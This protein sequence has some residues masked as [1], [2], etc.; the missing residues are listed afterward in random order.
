MKN[1]L[2]SSL[3]VLISISAFSQTNKETESINEYLKSTVIYTHKRIISNASQNVLAH[4]I[5]ESELTFNTGDEGSY[6]TI[7]SQYYMKSGKKFISFPYESEML[8]SPEFIASITAKKFKLITNDDGV[9]FQSIL[10]LMD[11]NRGLGFFKED[12]SWYFIRSKFFDDI[13]AYVVTTDNKGQITKL[14][15]VD[16]LENKLPETLLKVGESVRQKNIKKDAV[17][18]KDSA[19]MHN[20]LIEKANFVFEISPLDFYSINKI[21]TI[22]LNKCVLKITEGEEGMSSTSRHSFMLVSNNNEYIKQESIN[23]LLEMPLFISSLQE[24]YKI[25]TEEDARLFQYVLDD[26][27][28]VNRSDIALKTFYKKDNMWFF[29]REKSFDDLKGFILLTDDQNKV[30]YMDYTKINETSINRIK[31]KDKNFKVDYKFKLVSPATNKVTVKKGEGL[32]VEISFDKNMVNAK[33]CWIMTRFDGRD[34][35]TYAGS[36][37]NSPYTNG[38]TGGALENPHHTVE[39][40]L[41]KNGAEDTDDALGVIKIEITVEK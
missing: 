30:S 16:E 21:S 4:D 6:T 20:D 14:T 22:S 39:Y 24:K 34:H 33:G 5:I 1:I 35:G 15:Y 2:L 13:G 18:K 27:S 36:S 40:F 32:S 11:D 23:G 31:M 7:K 29:V 19:Y 3:I 12:N 17:S 38:I 37:I 26:L 25:E 28:P 8:A 41:L 10:K 9:A